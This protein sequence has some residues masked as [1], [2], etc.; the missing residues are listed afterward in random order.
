MSLSQWC[1]DRLLKAR[2]KPTNNGVLEAF[3]AP[4]RAERSNASWFMSMSDARDRIAEWRWPRELDPEKHSSNKLGETI[5]CPLDDIFLPMRETDDLGKIDVRPLFRPGL[6]HYM[7]AL[8]MCRQSE[9]RDHTRKRVRYSKTADIIE[10][11]AA[12]FRCRRTSSKTIDEIM[13]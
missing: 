6:Q 7:R 3:N 9:R 1:G 10:K 5:R 12:D 4:L 11:A 8:G 2:G 13:G